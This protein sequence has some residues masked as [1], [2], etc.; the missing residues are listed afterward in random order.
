MSIRLFLSFGVMLCAVLVGSVTPASARSAGACGTLKAA[1]ASWSI[2][3]INA[4]CTV[5]KA[6]LLKLVA[7]KPYARK[8]RGALIKP[9]NAWKACQVSFGRS[10]N[11]I[12][13]IECSKVGTALIFQRK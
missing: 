9:P 8:A 4:S 12:V 1:N 6:A 5:A 13:L 11:K 2:T 7:E 10:G 3:T